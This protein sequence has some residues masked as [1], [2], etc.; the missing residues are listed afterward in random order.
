MY[1][2]FGDAETFLKYGYSVLKNTQRK[3]HGYT[4]LQSF[5]K[6][7]FDVNNDEHIL[8]INELG[9]KLAHGLYPN[10]PVLVITHNDSE[11][12]CL[13]NHIIVLNH[14]LVTSKGITQNRRFSDVKKY[15]DELMC[16]YGLEI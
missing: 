10:S 6:T 15:N 12:E 11:G 8:E 2:D 1:S 3:V 13:H 4:L 16:K 14:D 7:E 9:K 5:P